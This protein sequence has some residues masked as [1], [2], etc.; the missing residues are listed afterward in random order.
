MGKITDAPNRNLKNQNGFT[1]IELIVTM[2]IIA[3]LA[4]MG[5]MYSGYL[6]NRAADSQAFTEGRHLLTALS[7]TFL[8]GEDVFFGDAGTVQAGDLG[9]QN[10]DK[11]DSRTPI[12]SLSSDV[13]A[14]LEGQ[15]TATDDGFV[16]ATVWHVNGTTFDPAAVDNPDNKKE[17]IFIVEESTGIVSAPSF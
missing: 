3:I 4:A 14:I 6:R 13:R 16:E 1:L 17:Y 2:M 5:S 15:N 8:G 7:D 9:T 10:H 11:S 12:F